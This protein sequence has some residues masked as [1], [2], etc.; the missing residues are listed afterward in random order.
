M[1]E[2]QNFLRY[3]AMIDAARLD[4]EPL[5]AA[6]AGSCKVDRT[7]LDDLHGLTIRY[8][9]NW[10]NLSPSALLP[11]VDQHL[12]GLRMLLG[13][14]QPGSE[15]Q[16]Q[17][18]A[19]ETAL[20]AG[21]LA[22]F[23]QQRRQ[24]ETYLSIANGYALLAGSGRLHSMALTLR[25]DLCS[26]VQSGVE[27]RSAEAVELLQAAERA[28]RRRGPERA[29]A[30]LRL[31]EEQAVLGKARWTYQHLDTADMVGHSEA[32]IFHKWDWRVHLAFRGNC[33]RMLGRAERAI[34][35]LVCVLESLPADTV[36]NRAAALTDL[37]PLH[38]EQGDIE[39]AC[40]TLT[41]AL[42]LCAERGGLQDRINR[43]V[44]VRRRHLAR[45]ASHPAV[46]RLDEQHRASLQASGIIR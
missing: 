41:Q 17:A 37:A 25:G 10:D 30:L 39:A 1:A 31:A 28:A 6:L 26:V 15:R 18:I 13:R 34:S 4:R 21:L 36:S 9:A 27:G 20:T 16:L 19:A 35:L 23:L 24:V 32:G 8:G 3:F 38:C 43:A 7:L 46:R 5:A 2:N 11:M 29:W 33:E 45:W 40:A 14:A 12:K 44:R 22:W 42:D